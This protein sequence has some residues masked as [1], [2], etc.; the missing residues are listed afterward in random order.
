MG[1]GHAPTRGTALRAAS[2][3]IPDDDLPPQPTDSGLPPPKVWVTVLER[4]DFYVMGA[5]AT[6]SGP[7]WL[8]KGTNTMLAP[9]VALPGAVG[10]L[11][12]PHRVFRG[13]P[14]AGI[15][16][17]PAPWPKS[18]QGGRATTW[19]WPCSASP[20]GSST[21]GHPR[22]PCPPFGPSPPPTQKFRQAQTR[23]RT[24]APGHSNP[25]PAGT[26]PSTGSSAAWVLAQ[27]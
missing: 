22:G 14:K 27:S 9:G 18:P 1:T 8:L 16:L 6:S 2:L 3:R 26:T 23:G 13:V 5:T 12:T 21:T 20:N 4:G 11:I 19:D 7:Q 17:Q 10:D 24:P 15:D 25:S